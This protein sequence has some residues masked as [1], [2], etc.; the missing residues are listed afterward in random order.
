MSVTLTLT[1]MLCCAC[2]TAH[3]ISVDGG[4]GDTSD[5]DVDGEMDALVPRGA[6]TPRADQYPQV[7]RCECPEPNAEVVGSAPSGPVQ[8]HHAFIGD[9]FWEG[10]DCWD[11]RMLFS[12]YQTVVG[13]WMPELDTEG[14]EIFIRSPTDVELVTGLPLSVEVSLNVG[15]RHVTEGT[16]VFEELVVDPPAARGTLE[17]REE[18]WEIA[19]TFDAVHCLLLDDNCL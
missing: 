17:I 11:L 18:G 13:Q 2:G 16:V 5:A 14:M 8:L 6:E 19:G 10:L 3:R 15:E 4:S 1:A 9:A 12:R 7:H